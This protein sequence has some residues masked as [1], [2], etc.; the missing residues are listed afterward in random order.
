MELRRQMR[1]RTTI[2]GL[3]VAVSLVAA[4]TVASTGA[5]AGQE[6]RSI[7]FSQAKILFEL[8]ATAQDAGIQALLDGEGW[9]HVT[10]LSPDREPL[11]EIE[12]DGSVGDI[13]VTELFFESAEPSL[14]DLPLEDLL[15]MFPEGRYRFEGTTV[16]GQ[17]LF[18]SAT[19]SHV[20]P[21][22]ANVVS[23]AEGATTD[24][25]NTVIA[26]EPVTE[27]AGIR[28]AGY[29]VIVELSDPLR[30]FSVDLPS[31]DTSVTVPSEF[32]EPGTDY[33]FEV[34]AVA[35]NNNQ[36]IHE[37]TFSTAG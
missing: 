5:S 23:P 10:V 20:I 25:A 12:A 30:V 11:L 16:E 28:I 36:T 22:K 4:A 7:P 3:V 1:R 8:N 31:T 33:K 2:G 21:A 15:A 34:L 14:A 9:D 37:G 26:W 35:D 6:Q 19:L 32:L 18:G 29:Q 13:G 24:P 17:R 27:P